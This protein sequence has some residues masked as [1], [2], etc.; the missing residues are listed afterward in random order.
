MR[1]Y[2]T[3]GMLLGYFTIDAQNTHSRSQITFMTACLCVSYNC[4]R[5]WFKPF[6][7]FNMLLLQYLELANR[8]KPILF[9]KK[10]DGDEQVSELH[11]NIYFPSKMTN[12]K[13]NTRGM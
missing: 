12:M 13:S 5:G 6:S 1:L 8:R 3:A 4:G 10:A 11:K 7:I 9:K 2:D